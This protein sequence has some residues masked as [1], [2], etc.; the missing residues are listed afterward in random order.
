MAL[1]VFNFFFQAEDGIRDGHVTG[2]Q[3]CALPIYLAPVGDGRTC[4]RRQARG[5]RSDDHI[6]AAD[7]SGCGRSMGA[8]LERSPCTL[9]AAAVAVDE[10]GCGGAISTYR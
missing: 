8:A 5:A 1:H 2:V 6:P 10:I 3:T 4:R 7:Q 9:L